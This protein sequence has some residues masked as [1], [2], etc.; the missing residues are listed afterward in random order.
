MTISAPVVTACRLMETRRCPF[1]VGACDNLC[2]RFESDD[3]DVWLEDVAIAGRARRDGLRLCE[4][5]RR[6]GVLR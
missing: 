3:E 6:D 1:V 5:A 4:Q 2:A